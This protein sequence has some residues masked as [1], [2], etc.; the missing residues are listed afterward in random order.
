MLSQHSVNME[1][2]TA[3]QSGVSVS[4]AEMPLPFLIFGT[5]FFPGL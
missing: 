4:L 3:N 2:K 1:S 5:Q